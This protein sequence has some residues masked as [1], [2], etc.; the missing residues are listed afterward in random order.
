MSTQKP[1]TYVSDGPYDVNSPEFAKALQR[2]Q[3]RAREAAKVQERKRKKRLRFRT[4][5]PY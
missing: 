3:E 2:A 1:D 4:P 5:S